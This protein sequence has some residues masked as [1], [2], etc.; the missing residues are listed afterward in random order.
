MVRSSSTAASCIRPIVSCQ[1]NCA[2]FW[3]SRYLASKHGSATYRKALGQRRA[4]RGATKREIA[5]PPSALMLLQKVTSTVPRRMPR[6]PLLAQ[7][8]HPEMS[9]ICPLSGVKRTSAMSSRTKVMLAKLVV[10]SPNDLVDYRLRVFVPMPCPTALADP[11]GDFGT[12]KNI[13]LIGPLAETDLL[14]ASSDTAALA[15]IAALRVV[16]FGHGPHRS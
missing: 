4:A 15:K 8:G 11:D 1:P 5:V 16:C 10:F 13:T 12:T 14:I 3:I 2:V 9:A 6:C 7:S